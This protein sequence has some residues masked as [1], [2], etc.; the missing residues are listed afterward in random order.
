MAEDKTFRYGLIV[1]GF[2]L[3]IVGMFIMNVDKPGVYATFFSIGILMI[4]V[5]IVWSICQCYPKVTH[6]PPIKSETEHLFPEKQQLPGSIS[7]CEVPLKSSSQSPYTSCEEAKHDAKNLPTYGQIQQNISGVEDSSEVNSPPISLQSKHLDEG[8]SSVK[9]KV[10]VHRDSESDGE[11]SSS[12]NDITLSA[13][14]KGRGCTEAPLATFKE[15]FDTAIN[16]S[17][18]NNL[19]LHRHRSVLPTSSRNKGQSQPAQNE[20]VTLVDAVSP[21]CSAQHNQLA[22]SASE[23]DDKNITS[24]ATAAPFKF[25]QP[26]SRDSQEKED[27][28]ASDMFYGIC[29][30]MN[31]INLYISEESEQEESRCDEI[32]V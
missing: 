23:S 28:I 2:F 26:A 4:I 22:I 14:I 7:E 19:A 30:E 3:I 5:G 1:L 8:Q 29:D 11:T 21:D 9:A 18:S 6:I 15:D 20:N 32:S 24:I 17:P 13:G 31:G 12:C 16:S 10:L 27:Q 25:E